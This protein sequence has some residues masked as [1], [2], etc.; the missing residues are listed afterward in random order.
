MTKVL[1]T[2][3]FAA[4]LAS[5]NP[6][7]PDL[8][9]APFL[10]AGQEPFCPDGYE[11][12]RGDDNRSICQAIFVPGGD[13][14]GID[15]TEPNDTIASSY[16]AGIPPASNFHL[17]N[18]E[19]CPSNDIDLFEV[20]VTDDDDF[21]FGEVKTLNGFAVEVGIIAADGTVVEAAT[22]T[23]PGT[24]SFE[25]DGLSSGAYYLRIRPIGG[26]TG[27]YELNISVATPN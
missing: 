5:C 9:A 16:S 2:S 1:L 4:F 11:C 17:L 25:T 13:C 10:C 3:C 12:V 14:D 18:V 27:T 23:T 19:L 20:V 24:Y 8:G 15:G 6:Y 7:D 26:V 21:I 22:Q